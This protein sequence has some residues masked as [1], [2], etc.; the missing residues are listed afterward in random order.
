[1]VM[2]MVM[3]GLALPRGASHPAPC[4]LAPCAPPRAGPGASA[5]PSGGAEPGLA[6]AV[7]GLA[8]AVPALCLLAE[9]CS[10]P[11]DWGR[12]A[13]GRRQELEGAAFD[14]PALF[15]PGP[16]ALAYC[17]AAKPKGRV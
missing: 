11:W 2:V 6:A 9:G 12:P 17:R 3:V 5:E 7:P 4:S 13:A 14:T 1:M 8:A 10:L 16:S 15:P